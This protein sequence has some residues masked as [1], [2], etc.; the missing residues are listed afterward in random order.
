MADM[1]FWLMVGIGVLV[2]L[3]LVVFLFFRKKKH[4]VNYYNLFVMGLIWAGVGIP[5]RNYALSAAGIIML[6]IGLANRKKWKKHKSWKKL[7]KEEQRIRIIVMVGLAVL[8]LVG[9][10]FFLLKMFA[11][12]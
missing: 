6:V 12:V 1:H 11:A 2:L 5:L 3:L 8:V 10:V 4:E 7:S 9:L